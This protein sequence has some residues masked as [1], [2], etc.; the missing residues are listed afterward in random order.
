MPGAGGGGGL[1]PSGGNY[2]KIT[3]NFNCA[4]APQYLGTVC[5]SVELGTYKGTIC[6]RGQKSA[7]TATIH[8]PVPFLSPSSNRRGC[9]C[10]SWPFTW[11]LF[12][13]A[14]L[15]IGRCRN[16]K[17]ELCGSYFKYC[18]HRHAHLI[19]QYTTYYTPPPDCT[20]ARQYI[21][22]EARQ[23]TRKL[24]SKIQPASEDDLISYHWAI[25]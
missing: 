4:S 24:W 3:F 8:H 23:G 6:L 7:I 16:T 1:I 12:L 25:I 18:F 15:T 22:A 2:I 5:R 10:L 20:L 17:Y 19:N 9:C 21:I 13:H 14:Y 11:R